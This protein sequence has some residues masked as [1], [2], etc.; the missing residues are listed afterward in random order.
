V[1]GR[2]DPDDSQELNY[3]AICQAIAE[4]GYD[5]YVGH[6]YAPRADVLASLRAMFALCDV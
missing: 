3:R 5:G 4:T 1:P 2:K 6:E